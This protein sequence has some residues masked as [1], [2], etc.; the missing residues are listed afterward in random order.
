M[1]TRLKMSFLIAVH[2]EL[3][4]D[5]AKTAFNFMDFRD[6]ELIFKHYH[7]RNIAI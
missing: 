6:F 5:M 2:C 4:C 7:F 1:L 3:D